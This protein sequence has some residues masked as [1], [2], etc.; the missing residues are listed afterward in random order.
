MN[1]LLKQL[2]WQNPTMLVH[3]SKTRGTHDLSKTNPFIG[4]SGNTKTSYIELLNT[5]LTPTCIING[6]YIHQRI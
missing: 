5:K 4:R 1:L 6:K 3:R 2:L